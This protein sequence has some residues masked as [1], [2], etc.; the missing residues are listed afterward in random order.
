M[1]TDQLDVRLKAV[2]L[3]GDLFSSTERPISE[4][5][6]PL[7]SE[8]LKR[9]TD[10]VVEVRISVIEHVKNFLILNPSRPE[11]PD[12]ICKESFF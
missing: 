6:R 5:F 10:R 11:A 1:Q 12:I 9:L 2:K 8:F 3:L 4:S 7:F